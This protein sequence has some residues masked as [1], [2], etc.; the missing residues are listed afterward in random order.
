[1]VSD[2]G[3]SGLKIGWRSAKVIVFIAA[4]AF[5]ACDDAASFDDLPEIVITANDYSF[6]A[7]QS[8]EGGMVRVTLENQGTESHQVELVKVIDGQGPD[9]IL[10]AIGRMDVEALNAM[11]IYHGGPNEVPPGSSLT[12]AGEL[13]PGT[14][15][16]LCFVSSPSGTLHVLQGMI[17]TMEVTDP[18]EDVSWTRPEPDVVVTLEDYRFEVEGEIDAGRRWVLVK[19]QGSEPHEFRLLSNGIAAA[20]GASTISPGE[21]TWL[22]LELS[23]GAMR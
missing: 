10:A 1:V 20:G 19:N 12:V 11:V 18:A 21:E 9:D 3:G 22:D 15:V 16:L 4:L 13:E 8:V 14:Y 23:S 6:E 2:G 17:G 5:G 7:P